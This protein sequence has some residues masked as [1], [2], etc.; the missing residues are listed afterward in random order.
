MKIIGHLV[1]Q[2]GVAEIMKAIDSVY[3]IVDEYYIVDGGS[4]DGTWQV[5]KRFQDAYNLTLFKNKFKNLREQR[6]FL[7]DKT[8][9]N[10]WVVTIDQDEKFSS[11]TSKRLRDFIHRIDVKEYKKRLPISVTLPLLNLMLNPLTM[12]NDNC[13]NTN[14]I[15]YYDKG[16]RFSEE[17]HCRVS[18]DK[19]D[20]D[21]HQ[22]EAPLGMAVLHYARLDK[23]RYDDWEKDKHRREY[24]KEEWD[25]NAKTVDVDVLWT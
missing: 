20:W 1:C 9:Y 17:Y 15:F 12:R 5:L 3:P 6:N 7:L 11:T 21:Y 25:I 2:N 23:K 4:T 19:N 18:Y 13:Y 8:E 14:K 24:K 10:N 22:I 16:L